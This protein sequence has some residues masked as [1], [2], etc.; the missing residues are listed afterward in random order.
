MDREGTGDAG[1]EFD[2]ALDALGESGA[3]FLVCGDVPPDVHERACERWLGATDR[4][5]I[6]ARTI[7]T[8]AADLAMAETV[9]FETTLRSAA[10]APAGPDAGVDSISGLGTALVD[11]IGRLE[12]RTSEPGELRVCVE[13]LEPLRRRYDDETVFRFL[14]LLTNRVRAADGLAH[15]HLS[16]GPDAELASTL[17]SLFDGVV[18]LRT[19]GGVPEER[20]HLA[21]PELTTAWLPVES[22]PGP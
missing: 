4:T 16:T 2:R 21:E 6:V 14:H 22:G 15:V 18:T 20:W 5:R 8:R 1:A 13:A 17:R 3:A 9:S 11:A 12:P 19:A 10:E 7:G